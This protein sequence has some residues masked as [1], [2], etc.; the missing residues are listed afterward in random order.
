MASPD[1]TLRNFLFLV[2][3]AVVAGLILFAITHSGG[4]QPGNRVSSNTGTQS[5]PTVSS[6]NP[7][8]TGHNRYLSTVKK[9]NSTLV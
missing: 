3:V 2:A 1:H 4:S 8:V 7:T 6:V 5:T 9:R